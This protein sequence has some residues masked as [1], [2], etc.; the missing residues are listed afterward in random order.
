[1]TG[2]RPSSAGMLQ[3]FAAGDE[4]MP[5]HLP[6]VTPD[7]LKT[8][9]RRLRK[10]QSRAPG[11]AS[12]SQFYEQAARAL[13]HPSWAKAQEHLAAAPVPGP[14]MS[15]NVESVL[16]Q[17][18]AA[19]L[20]EVVAAILQRDDTHHAMWQGRAL[21]FMT[22]LMAALVH[23]RDHA[24]WTLSSE[25][26]IGHLSLESTAR[27][28]AHPGLPLTIS[29]PLKAY[30]RSIPYYEEGRLQQSEATQDMHGFITMMLI[31][32][33]HDLQ[34]VFSIWHDD[35]RRREFFSRNPDLSAQVLRA[36]AL[37]VK[38][39]SPDSSAPS[40]P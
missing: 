30:L 11:D 2:A 31:P 40:P 3:V 21:S 6:G 37:E 19:D 26:L 15:S 5:L 12:L 17:G 4:P 10:E 28:A 20:T 9:L 27:I 14:P 32:A 1:M 8:F 18:S 16:Q 36:I 24:G 35:Q 22:A 25:V 13:G 39:P 38:E 33:V 23:L 7:S 34:A 29:Q